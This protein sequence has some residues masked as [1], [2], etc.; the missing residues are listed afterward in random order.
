M[1]LEYLNRIDDAVLPFGRES[2]T[3]H[4]KYLKVLHLNTESSA[5]DVRHVALSLRSKFEKDGL[6]AQTVRALE[7]SL[8]VTHDT[9]NEAEFLR[10]LLA[11]SPFQQI[12]ADR[13]DFR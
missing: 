12:E 3:N 5:E 2:G 11:D 1:S 9:M 4:K 10:F 13:F 7:W 6:N 8:K